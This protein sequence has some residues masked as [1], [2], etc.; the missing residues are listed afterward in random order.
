[1][2][3]LRGWLVTTGLVAGFL[4]A[5]SGLARSHDIYSDWKKPGTALSCCNGGPTGDC[6]DT[7]ARFE[8]GQWFALRR[9]DN[10]E[11]P[12][13]PEAIMT[14]GATPDGKAHLCAPAPLSKDDT[15]IYCFRAPYTGG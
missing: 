12:I 2:I 13:P 7:Q 3:Q 5:L 15:R 1:M 6:Y 4:L 14:D 11:L 9:E 10:R 8:H